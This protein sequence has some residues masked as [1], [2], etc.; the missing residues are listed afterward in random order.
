M[1]TFQKNNIK[2]DQAGFTFIELLL[3]LAIFIVVVMASSD[4]FSRAQRAQ[5]RALGIQ[6]LQDDIRTVVTKIANDVRT[7]GID[8]VC[9]ANHALVNNPC[10]EAMD[11]VVGNTVLALKDAQ[12]NSLIIKLA[13]TA[14]DGCS[15]AASAPCLLISDDAGATWNPLTGSGIKVDTTKTRFFLQPTVDPCVLNDQNTYLSNQQPRVQIRLEESTEVRGIA[16]PVH[17]SIQTLVSTREYK[18]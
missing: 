6:R 8:Y 10:G 12:D 3:V 1:D 16:D 15:D 13:A 7:G 4:I 14:A 2:A 9:Y 18:R 17:L 5:Q 11:P